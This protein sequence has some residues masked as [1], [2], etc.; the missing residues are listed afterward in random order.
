MNE[1]SPHRYVEEEEERSQQSNN[2][3]ADVTKHDIYHED[4]AILAD[5]GASHTEGGH[6]AALKLAKDGHVCTSLLPGSGDL[7]Y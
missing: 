1:K 4:G 7:Q 6:T 3:P 5:I 2:G